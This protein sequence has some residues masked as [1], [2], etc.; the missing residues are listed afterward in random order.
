MKVITVLIFILFSFFSVSFADEFIALKGVKTIGLTVQEIDK[1]CNLDHTD[2]DRNTRFLLANS[3][4]NVEQE[5]K[6]QLWIYPILV[7]SDGVACAG[8]II[9]QIYGT[10]ETTFNWGN[11]LQGPFMLYE[12][13]SVV[14]GNIDEFKDF[15]LNE[16]DNITKQFIADWSTVN[17]N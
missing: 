8:S 16:T 5:S 14:I 13:F 12:R 17:K 10:I 4:V 11:P 6:I 2:I 1:T 15:Y 7:Q 3:K 9:F